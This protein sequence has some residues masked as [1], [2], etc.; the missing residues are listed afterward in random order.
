MEPISYSLVLKSKDGYLP[1]GI[2]NPDDTPGANNIDLFYLVTA[3][4]IFRRMSGIQ[5]VNMCKL[6]FVGME[7]DA[8]TSA[9]ALAGIDIIVDS[10][11]IMNTTKY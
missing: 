11:Y 9:N 6:E 3:N 1:S 7:F 4:Q 5:G 2:K 10:Q 8:Q